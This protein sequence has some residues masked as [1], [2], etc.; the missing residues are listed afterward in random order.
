MSIGDYYRHVE[1]GRYVQVSGMHEWCVDYVRD[2]GMTGRMGSLEFREQYIYARSTPTLDPPTVPVLS[3]HPADLKPRGQKAPLYL[4]PWEAV[5]EHECPII[6]R[7]AGRDPSALASLCLD[8]VGIDEVAR[9]F[10]YGAKKYARDNWRTFT[11]DAQAEDEYFGA[12]CRHLVRDH[13]GETVDP[14]SGCPHVAHAAAGAL[15]WLARK[16]ES[17]SP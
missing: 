16:A 2:D 11:W 1:T 12:I 8:R 14:E 6:L 10:E 4:I 15:I 7:R 3:Q 5:P 13:D 9:V 17:C